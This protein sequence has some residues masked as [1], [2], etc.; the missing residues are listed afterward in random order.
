MNSNDITFIRQDLKEL[1]KKVNILNNRLDLVEDKIQVLPDQIPDLVDTK[2]P[3]N[4]SLCHCGSM[5]KEYCT[6][7]LW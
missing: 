2:Y 4:S 5:P 1:L 6:C 7:K 3:N